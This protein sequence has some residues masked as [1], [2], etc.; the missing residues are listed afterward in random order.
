MDGAKTPIDFATEAD[1]ETV[2]GILEKAAGKSKTA[3]EKSAK[4]AQRK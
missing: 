3:E 2:I 4:K 1:D